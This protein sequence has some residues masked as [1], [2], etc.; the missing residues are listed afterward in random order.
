MVG[1]LKFGFS[2]YFRA[3]FSGSEADSPSDG[4]ICWSS[5]FGIDIRSMIIGMIVDAMNL[6][7][8]MSEASIEAW[9]TLMDL[10]D[11]DDMALIL[12]RQHQFSY[13]GNMQE[14]E[15]L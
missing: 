15:A 11:I 14:S 7:I 10:Y 4:M 13:L 1:M 8:K 6:H 9:A 3:G 5:L 2:T 12:K